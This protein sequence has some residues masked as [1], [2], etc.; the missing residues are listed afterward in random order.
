VCPLGD[1]VE[2]QELERTRRVGQGVLDVS[3]AVSLK[4]SDELF[5]GGIDCGE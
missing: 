2:R 4:F 1:G 3:V 5:S